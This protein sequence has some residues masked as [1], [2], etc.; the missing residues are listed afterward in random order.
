VNVSVAFRFLRGG[1]ANPMPNP[2]P[3][4]ELGTGCWLRDLTGG[5]DINIQLEI[6]CLLVFRI[7]YEDNYS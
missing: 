4:S 2:P 5:V 3:L 7:S 6:N 1:V